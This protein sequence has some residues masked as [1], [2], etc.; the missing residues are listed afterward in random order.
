MLAARGPVYRSRESGTSTLRNGKPE[1]FQ[2]G[3]G[4]TIEA[5]Y[6]EEAPLPGAAARFAE[7]WENVTDGLSGR[8]ARNAFRRAHEVN[9][10]NPSGRQT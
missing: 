5:V 7:L 9:I 1:P 6:D 4:C 10:R 8:D 2:D 3:C